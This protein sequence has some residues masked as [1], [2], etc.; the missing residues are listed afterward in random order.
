MEASKEFSE[1]Q[2]F[3]KDKTCLLTGATGFVGKLVLEKIL[4]TLQVKHLY[5]LC[6]DKHGVS[7]E[8][9]CAQIFDSVVR[10]SEINYSNITFSFLPVLSREKEGGLTVSF[11][12]YIVHT[13]I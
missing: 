10:Y 2:Q 8:D 3:F 9:R 5:I 11:Y 4:R 12:T 6:R 1:I 13:A 7:A